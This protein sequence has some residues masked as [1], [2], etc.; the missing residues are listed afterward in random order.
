MTDGLAFAGMLGLRLTIE[1]GNC[2]FRISREFL[3]GVRGIFV[4][5]YFGF[6]RNI[7]LRC[8]IE[9]LGAGC[10]ARCNSL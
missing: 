10:F 4:V 8:D 1:D 6:D 3:L 7:T 5:R 2:Y 9:V